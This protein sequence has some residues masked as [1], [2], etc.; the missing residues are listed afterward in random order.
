MFGWITL[1]LQFIQQTQRLSDLTSLFA[2][3]PAVSLNCHQVPDAT[4]SQRSSPYL[5]SHIVNRCSQ[6]A[7]GT[8]FSTF[9]QHL[10]IRHLPSQAASPHQCRGKFCKPLLNGKCARFF[11]VQAWRSLLRSMESRWFCLAQLVWSADVSYR[12]WPRN[13][14]HAETEHFLAT[15]SGVF[16]C[17]SA[18]GFHWTFNLRKASRD[19]HIHWFPCQHA[20]HW[21]ESPCCPLGQLPRQEITGTLL[22]NP[23]DVWF[24]MQPL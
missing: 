11:G 4:T 12:F 16:D 5:Q 17:L 20:L 6:W 21:T 14:A 1:E 18:T 23:W 19:V 13:A 7:M 10:M 8:N 22:E 3:S 24:S 9:L 15:S 2:G